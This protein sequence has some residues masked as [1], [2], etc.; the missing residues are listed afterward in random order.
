MLVILVGIDFYSMETI[1]WKSMT[2][3]NCL[4]INILQSIFSCVQQKK[5]IQVWNKVEGE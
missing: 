1:Q 4:V 5:L 2:A 3:N